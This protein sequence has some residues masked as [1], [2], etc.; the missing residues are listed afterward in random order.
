MSNDV[1][2]R[3]A[4]W[5]KDQMRGKGLTAEAW[6]RQA[7][8]A[9]TT[10]TRFLKHFESASVPSAV[11]LAKLGEVV[12]S[13]PRLAGKNTIEMRVVPVY[14][15]YEGSQKSQRGSM[16]VEHIEVSGD[17]PADCYA[18]IVDGTELRAR[19]IGPGSTLIVDP[20]VV[21]QQ[22]DIVIAGINGKL[23][24]LVYRPPLLLTENY[25]PNE[26]HLL[27]DVPLFGVAIRAITQLR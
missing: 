25:G 12:D 6:C 13:S 14:S 18:V 5:L 24:P 7:G 15:Y 9:P 1:K 11:S 19:S 4:A 23:V 21:P 10:I 16:S 22:G 27:Q 26:G 17:V 8:I 2:Y 20:N 3:V